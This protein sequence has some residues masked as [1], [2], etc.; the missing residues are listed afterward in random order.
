M[1]NNKGERFIFEI[2][3]ETRKLTTYRNASTGKTDFNGK[4]LVPSL[5]APLNVSGD[6]ITFDIFVDQ[7]SIE[8]FTE[9]SSMSMTNLIF[10]KSIYN[11]LSV[12]GVFYKAEMRNLNSIWK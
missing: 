12:Y 6:S 9:N 2:N 4:F 5:D 1:K 7:S 11:Y 3:F 8:I 10:H